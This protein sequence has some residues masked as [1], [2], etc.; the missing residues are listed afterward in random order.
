MPSP[1]LAALCH[2]R[3]RSPLDARCAFFAAQFLSEDE[4]GNVQLRAHG[5]AFQAGMAAV[6]E[7]GDMPAMF[8]GVLALEDAW[9]EGFDFQ[10]DCDAMAACEDCQTGDVCPWHG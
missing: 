6:A 3:I 4:A 7:H 2:C 10:A 9:K 5:F 1:H 8:S